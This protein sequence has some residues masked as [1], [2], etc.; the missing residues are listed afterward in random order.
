MGAQQIGKFAGLLK[1]DELIGTANVTVADDDL[2]KRVRAEP[3]SQIS[4]HARKIATSLDLL[5]EDAF[6]AKSAFCPKAM[7]TPWQRVDHHLDHA[8][9][10]SD[11]ETSRLV[12]SIA[13]LPQAGVAPSNARNSTLRVC[14][15]GLWDWR[16]VAG[17]R[18]GTPLGSC[19][20]AASG[21]ALSP[22]T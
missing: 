5:K 12:A 6:A 18:I 9:I 20:L 16:R 1:R 4:A 3:G 7:N 19:R 15:H 21:A 17:E 8:H 14:R 10:L 2:R 11:R 22:A 13:T